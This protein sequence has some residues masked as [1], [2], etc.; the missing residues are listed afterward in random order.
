MG[1]L[2]LYYDNLSSLPRKLENS[3]PVIQFC[4]N[5]HGTLNE[6]IREKIKMHAWVVSN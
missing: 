1:F 4:A 5:F 6:K 3:G 2:L